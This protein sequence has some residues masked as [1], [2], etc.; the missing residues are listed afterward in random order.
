MKRINVDATIEQGQALIALH[1]CR[2][3]EHD[4]GEWDGSKMAISA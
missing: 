1:V 2:D 3:S 4:A